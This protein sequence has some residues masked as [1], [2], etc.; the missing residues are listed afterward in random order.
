ML[1]AFSIISILIG[2]SLLFMLVKIET[3]KKS[4]FIFI[5]ITVSLIFWIPSWFDGLAGTYLVDY[6]DTFRTIR[7]ETII[8]A[9]LYSYIGV[10]LYI[11]GHYV[12]ESIGKTKNIHFQQINSINSTEKLLPLIVGLIATWIACIYLI[13]SF[14][15]EVFSFD[16][17]EARSNI[18]Y[19]VTFLIQA[20]PKFYIGYI[21]FFIYKKNA[22]KATLLTVNLLA[23]FFSI[24][25]TRQNIIQIGVCIAIYAV[26]YWKS[27][28]IR[29]ILA[30]LS[31]AII[32]MIVLSL[33]LALRNTA[34]IE[35]RLDLIT[36]LD[37]SA[38]ID[39]IN[40]RDAELRGVY[41]SFIENYQYIDFWQ[42]QYLFRTA[43][44]WLP[45]T[46][47][48]GIKPDDFEYKMFKAFTGEDAT[49]HPTFFGSI[50][51]DSGPLI[52]LWIAAILLVRQF[53]QNII[54]KLDGSYFAASYVA[55]AMSCV[56]IGRGAIYSG[57]LVLVSACTMY[58]IL[59]KMKFRF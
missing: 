16:F 4:P 10:V 43:L 50:F 38:L 13:L 18:P 9:Q 7:G 25:G 54:S 49:M 47:S 15:V 28:V 23:F 30:I 59:Q 55:S 11:L 42:L 32:G 44:F 14:G 31:A 37:I 48:M 52:P 39:L 5:W 45:S 56:M 8:I 33:T 51:A 41:Y 19:A 2:L 1:Y 21:L 22:I 20:L 46:L 35:S 26:V 6:R 57:V 24:G 58:S 34:G 36:S 53:V 27:P 29:K 3:Q 12:L 40:L 17:L